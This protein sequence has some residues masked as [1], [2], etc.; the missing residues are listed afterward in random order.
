MMV[1]MVDRQGWEDPFGPIK[2]VRE[3]GVMVLNDGA[4][5]FGSKARF[6]A[7]YVKNLP[8]EELVYVQPRQG[9]AGIS[10]CHL[11]KM[12]NKRLTLFMP[13]SAKASDY[14]LRTIELGAEPRFVRIA[15]MPNLNGMAQAYAEKAGATFIPLG[16]K[17]PMV[18]A[19][20]VW[21]IHNFL[22]SLPAVPLGEMWSVMSTGVLSRAL[23]IALIPDGWTV[24][25]VAVARNIQEGELGQAHFHT[26]DKPFSTPTKQGPQLFD[27]MS[28]YDAKGFEYLVKRRR[29]NPTGNPLWFWNVAG[30]IDKPKL[31]A[32]EVDSNREWGDLTDVYKGVKL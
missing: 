28:T 8:T 16:L 3:S 21:T 19:G 10:L 23:Q 32:S 15:A 14:Q 12:Y 30:N 2:L 17:H 22:S 31:D 5:D 27:S 7:L 25:A 24:H 13:A 6:G 4:G 1:D 20:A 26:Y 18:T 9:W 11:A 29:M